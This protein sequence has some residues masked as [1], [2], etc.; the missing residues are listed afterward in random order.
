MKIKTLSFTK[1]SGYQQ[2]SGGLDLGIP[3]ALPSPFKKGL[4]PA[5][6][7]L[8]ELVAAYH[9]PTTSPWGRLAVL[10]DMY[11]TC[12]F[13]LRACGKYPVLAVLVPSLEVLYRTIVDSLCRKF[14]CAVNVLPQ[15]LE[16]WWGRVLTKHGHEV[17]A[18][19]SVAKYLTRAEVEKYRLSFSKG[20]AFMRERMANNA[21]KANWVAA[22]SAG[23]GW[24]D[25]RGVK[26]A[27]MMYPNYA[28]FALSMGR[29]FFMAHHKGCFHKDNFFHSSYL[30][31]DAVLCTGT[32]HIENGVVLG[33]ANDSGHYQPSLDHLLN[34][35][36]ALK[37]Y[38]CNLDAVV[39]HAMWDS[40][41]PGMKATP[42]GVPYQYGGRWW[43]AVNGTT[44]LNL[45]SGGTA[46][47]DRNASN[48]ANIAK[49]LPK[50]AV[51]GRPK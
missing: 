15:R 41:S 6:D 34:V 21:V 27:P 46:L 7:R 4:H 45:R 44:L 19:P 11:F 9:L 49:R 47:L 43:V 38:G 5:V 40:L 30:A 32:L 36:Q 20:A 14:D 13:A 16:D 23:I 25:A 17:D 29:E 8:F 26:A 12:D 31:G 48:Q 50:G 37:M 22:N 18:Q 24:T 2:V 3:R 28:G 39:F 35:A 1:T 33:V 42:P 10:G 51:L